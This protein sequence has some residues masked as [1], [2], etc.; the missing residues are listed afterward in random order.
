MGW[1]PH[2]QHLPRV[3]LRYCPPPPHPFVAPSKAAD[4]IV[5][6]RRASTRR[7]AL[8]AGLAPVIPA[9]ASGKRI[10]VPLD[11]A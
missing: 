10:G 3:R 1:V 8:A 6:A 5:N 9:A 11:G 4:G 2:W 7:P